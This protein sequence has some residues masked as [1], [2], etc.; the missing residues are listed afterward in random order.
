M[1]SCKIPSQVLEKK[2][3]NKPNKLNTKALNLPHKWIFYFVL[4]KNLFISMFPLYI[5][6]AGVVLQRDELLK[7]YR[8]SSFKQLRVKGSLLFWLTFIV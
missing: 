5:Q 6:Y 2:K 4:L 1:I 8:T 3:V 7:A